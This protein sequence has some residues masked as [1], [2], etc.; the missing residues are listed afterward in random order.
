VLAFDALVEAAVA[1]EPALFSLDAAFV[2][3]VDAAEAEPAAP[4]A[5]FDAAFAEVLAADCAVSAFVSAISALS[6][7][8]SAPACANKA[9]VFAAVAAAASDAAAATLVA[10]P[11]ILELRLTANWLSVIEPSSKSSIKATSGWV[12]ADVPMELLNG[13]AIPLELTAL[14][15]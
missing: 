12:V 1:K 11:V 15:Q 14:T 6:S 2:A 4:V 7:A 13:P 8:V 3:D 5:E 9:A 10:T